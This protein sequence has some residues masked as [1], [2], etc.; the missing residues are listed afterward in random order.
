MTDHEQAML[1]AIN[2]AR[3]ARGLH[4]LAADG[5]LT[6]AARGHASDLRDHPA[7]IASGQYHTGSDGSTI[8]QRI[9]RAGYDAA[10][11]AEV[12]A[13]GWQGRVAP[14]L[15]WW[16]NSPGHV[17]Y[18]LATNVSDIGV[19]FASGG[20]WG[21]Y[22]TVNTGRRVAPPE[23]PRPYTS[24]VP[25]VVGGAA[26]APA[27]ADLLPYLCGDGRS[28]RV[29]NGW[30]SFEVF[31]C[32]REGNTFWQ[33]KAW[34]DLSVVNYEE[35]VLSGDYIGRDVDTSPGG[36]RFYRQYGAPWVKRHM[37]VGESFTQA[38]RVQFFRL[39]DCAPLGTHSGHVTD[40]IT[41]VEH[42][43]EWRSPFGFIVPDVVVLRWEQGGEVYRYARGFGLVGWARAHDD[44]HS[45]AWSGISEMRPDV[46]RLA[47]RR[48]PCLE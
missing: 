27:T 5:Q 42:L 47:R 38:K 9:A 4:A 33:L 36:G 2:A 17:G 31:Q 8:G 13:W 35:F 34:D 3:V 25:V 39:D 28:Y 11:Y 43:P 10:Q 15:D 12:T 48:V 37:R 29:G 40:T 46:G 44:P 7:L 41:L 14:A 30:G 16:L 19:G 32:Q 20:P 45:P 26:P 6:E 1:A 24:H 23:P 22:W 18:I 21:A